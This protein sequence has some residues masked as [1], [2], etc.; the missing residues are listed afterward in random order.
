MKSR[1]IS[2]CA[3]AAFLIGTSGPLLAAEQI[4]DPAVQDKWS[5]NGAAALYLEHCSSCHGV[6]RLG[7]QGPA[8]LP[9]NL[10]R[11]GKKAAEE[12]I[13]HG[14]AATQMPGFADRLSTEQIT[15]LAE[16]VYTPLP[17]TP[18]WTMAD[19]DVHRRGRVGQFL[20]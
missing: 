1:R 16:L 19:I 2:L 4:P 12:V 8:L 5:S 18:N 7:G 20:G 13:A 17:S 14:R 11:L 6:A 3:I 9:E 15:A 10:G